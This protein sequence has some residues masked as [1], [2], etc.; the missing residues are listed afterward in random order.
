MK[1]ILDRIQ[2]IVE[3]ERITV[4]ALE[5]QIGASKG[6]LSGAMLKGTD[7]QSKWLQK[8]VENYPLYNTEW[9]ITGHGEMLKND[10]SDVPAEYKKTSKLSIFKPEDLPL[11]AGK[12][13]RAPIYHSYPVSAGNMGLSVVRT[14]K[15]DSYCYTT[16][17]GVVFFPVV[18]CSFE[19][20]IKAGSYIGVVKVDKWDRLD[21]DKIYFIVT[22]DDRMIKR[23]RTD[24]DDSNILWCVSPNFSE[25]KIYKAE[26]IE[27]SHVFFYGVMV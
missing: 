6:V 13:Y 18:G 10:V 8:I 24:N 23:L 7:I 17:P 3:N 27:I 21:T 12:L 25:F 16:M 2:Q 14:D 5:R 26:I 11:Q 19:P 20:I 22:H 15:P 9:L 4:T 1:N